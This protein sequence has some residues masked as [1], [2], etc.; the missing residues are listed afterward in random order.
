MN[1]LV[2]INIWYQILSG[3]IIS[4]TNELINPLSDACIFAYVSH[5]S[6]VLVMM[7]QN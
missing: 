3:S 5:V 4:S 6:A 7:I 1:S 2:P